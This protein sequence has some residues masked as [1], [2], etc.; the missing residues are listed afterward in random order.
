MTG[1]SPEPETRR[2]PSL[3]GRAAPEI[4]VGLCVFNGEPYLAT[5]LKSLLAQEDADFELVIADNC[6]TDGTEELCRDAA[7]NDPRVRYLRREKNLGVIANH[8]RIVQET[9][10]AFFSFAGADD[11]YR[12]DRLTLL[13]AA[14]RARPEASIAFSSAEEIDEKGDLLEVWHNTA[15]TDHPDPVTRLH[16]KLVK[17]DETL[18]FYGLIRREILLRALPLQPIVAC[19]RVL[20]AQ[21]ALLGP[22]V[23]VAEPLLRHRNHARSVSRANHARTFRKREK[24]EENPRFFLP[25]AA[26][27]VALL[28]AIRHTPLSGRDRLRAYAA[29]RP[30]LRRNAVPMAKNVAHAGLALVRPAG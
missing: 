15:P 9:R 18:Q 21:L 19:D 20:I 27:G 30:W 12:A 3:V 10:G 17:Y 14:L 2:A 24:P 23:S 29:M 26:E 22:L 5:A 11:E 25:N 6:S 16:A 13:A 4:G 28:R 8:N 1:T 7:R